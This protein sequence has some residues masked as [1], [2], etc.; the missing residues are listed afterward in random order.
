M[1]RSSL[2]SCDS[3]DTSLPNPSIPLLVSIVGSSTRFVVS[4]SVLLYYSYTLSPTATLLVSTAVANAF[5]GKTVK[6]ILSTPRPANSPIKDPKDSG[7]PSSHGVS[8]G[9]LSASAIVLHPLGTLPSLLLLGY[10]GV[11][12]WYRVLRGLHTWPQVIVGYVFGATNAAVFWNSPL[13]PALEGCI[14]GAMGDKVDFKA[15]GVILVAGAIVVGWREIA[16]ARRFVV[17]K[18]K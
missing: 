18:G 12:L 8:L 1:S 10:C 2:K 6:R 5:L 13:Y 17:K 9:Y 3:G 15:A 7:M 14:R 11:G 16:K 4:S